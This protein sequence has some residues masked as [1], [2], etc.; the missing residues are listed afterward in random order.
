M[1]VLTVLAFVALFELGASV[2]SKP[3]PLAQGSRLFELAGL[4]VAPG[5]NPS[6][7][8]ASFTVDAKPDAPTENVNLFVIVRESGGTPFTL[9]R[10]DASDFSDCIVRDVPGQAAG[11]AALET[12]RVKKPPVLIGWRTRG[13]LPVDQ[14]QARK[15]V[16]TLDNLPPEGWVEV[17]LSATTQDSVRG[18]V[19][20][21]LSNALLFKLEPTKPRE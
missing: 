21:I 14:L 10:L 5:A 11:W 1:R 6:I 4:T 13:A 17:G 19:E 12:C 2:Q 20:R 15:V 7:R 16:V 3:T 9:L 8:T 18:P